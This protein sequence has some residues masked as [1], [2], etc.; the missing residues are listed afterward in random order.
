MGG[1]TLRMGAVTICLMIIVAGAFIYC[2]AR[3]FKRVRDYETIVFY[4]NADK[5]V[6]TEASSES[7]DVVLRHASRNFAYQRRPRAVIV[8]EKLPAVV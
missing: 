8:K 3:V 1:Y 7:G 4:K 6:R 2:R 5:V